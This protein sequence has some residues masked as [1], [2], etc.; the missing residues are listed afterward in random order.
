VSVNNFLKFGRQRK[1]EMG[2]KE[3]VPYLRHVDDHVISTK[4]G[5]LL[6]VIKLDGLPFQTMD[7]SELNAR[8]R[9]RNGSLRLMNS[10]SFSAYTTIIR[11]H[12]PPNLDD[13]FDSPFAADLNRRYVEHLRQK[14]LFVNE[15]YLTVI[16]RPMLGKIGWVDRVLSAFGDTTGDGEGRAEALRELHEVTAAF[17]RDFAAYGARQLGVVER[18]GSIFSEPAEFFAQILSGGEPVEMP[19]PRMSLAEAIPT[20][21]IFFGRTSLEIRSGDMSRTKLGA[22]VS[23]KEYPPFTAPGGTDG[24][25][26]LPYEFILTQ[27]FAVEDRAGAMKIMRRV[28]NQISGSDEGGTQMEASVR[29]GLDKLVQGETIFGHHHLSLCVFEQSASRLNRAVSDV[30]SELSRMSVV[31]VRESLNLEPAFWAQLPGNFGY[32]ARRGLISSLNFA[33]LFSGHNFPS[34]EAEGLHW[35]KP[36]AVIETANQTA[37]NFNFHV[38]DTGNFTVVGPTGS[39]KTVALC[40]LLAQAMRVRPRPRCIY[41][42]KDRGADIFIRALGGHYELLQP[43]IPTGFAPLQLEDTPANRNFAIALLG[44]LLRPSEGTLTAS[45]RM[46]ISDAVNMLFQFPRQRR[47]LTMVTEV[48]RGRLPPGENDLVMRLEPWLDGGNKGW[49]FSNP[50]DTLDFSAHVI[51][52]DMT[53]ILDEPETRTAALMYLFH[54]IEQAL[55]GDP[56]MIFLDEGWKLLDDAVFPAFLR[57]MLKTIRKKNGIVGFGT[58]SAG[59]IAQSAISSAIIEQT[60]TNIFFPN[61]KANSTVYR[62]YFMLSSKELEFVRN[63]P[64]ESRA[65]LI[66]HANDSVIVRLD[67]STM[68]DMIKVL[69]ARSE[70]V[71]ECEELRALHGEDPASWLPHFMKAGDG[72]A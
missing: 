42:D 67:L 47:T 4:S 28:G 49:L 3:H 52:F 64:I 8:L 9:S 11:R 30:Q 57:D 10:S 6:S 45:E 51:G 58:Q 29:Q 27:S 40:F 60:A 15:I 1:H 71:R 61:S 33:G 66:K 32:I 13:D 48:L 50:A 14:N 26:R 41:F 23:L 24:L 53:R 18:R 38:N 20:A 70:T 37:F 39:G 22:M 63:A 54:R 59:D 44:Y 35:K 43:G 5:V 12:S 69:S 19:L 25:L 21:Q 17:T 31:P 16:R 56:T 55:D 36:I 34:G 72:K 65:V 46:V 2:V 62:D 7:Q 68:P